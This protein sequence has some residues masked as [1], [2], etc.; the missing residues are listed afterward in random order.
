MVVMMAMV[1]EL[2][3]APV[4]VVMLIGMVRLLLVMMLI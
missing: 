3:Q 4:L 1:L 2:S